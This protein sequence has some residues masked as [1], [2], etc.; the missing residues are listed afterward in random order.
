MKKIEALQ[1]AA[2][3]LNDLIHLKPQIVID[4]RRKNLTEKLHIAA[5]LLEPGD[6]VSEETKATLKAIGADIGR[7]FFCAGDL[8]KERGE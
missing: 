8:S 5:G 3:E 7:G 1:N 2:R 4:G 6:K